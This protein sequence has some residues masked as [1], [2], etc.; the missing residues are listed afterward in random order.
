[1]RYKVFSTMYWEL[2]S[3]I[4]MWLVLEKYKIIQYTNVKSMH[5][6]RGCNYLDLFFYIDVISNY[7]RIEPTVIK[8]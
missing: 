5:Y 6:M 4:I 1:M 3:L 8:T 2:S 7:V